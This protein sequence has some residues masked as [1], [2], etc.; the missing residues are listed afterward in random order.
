MQAI[1]VDKNY[2]MG[3]IR[4]SLSKDNT[5]EEAVQIAESIIRIING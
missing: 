1:D 4:V 3:T 5:E 2:V